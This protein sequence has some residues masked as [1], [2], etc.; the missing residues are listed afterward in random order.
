MTGR[1]RGMSQ[2]D[3]HKM[4]AIENTTRNLEINI[5][6]QKPNDKNIITEYEWAL[7][8]IEGHFYSFIS[9]VCFSQCRLYDLR[10]DREVAIYSKE[11][12]IFGASSV[13]FSLSGQCC[14]LHAYT[15]QPECSLQSVDFFF[16]LFDF[17]RQTAVWWIQRLHHQRVGRSK[18]DARIHF[19]RTREQS[20]YPSR[21]SRRDLVLLRVLGSHFTG[22]RAKS[23]FRR[24]I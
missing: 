10:A 13:D 16:S 18:G 6:C 15:K 22:T 17:S 20:Q 14:H 11:S 23:I 3:N 21:L 9:L 8:Q 4:H 2:K 7:I 19:V 24:F 12:I 5:K 1:N